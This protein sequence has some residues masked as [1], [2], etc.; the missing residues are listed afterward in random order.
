MRTSVFVLLLLAPPIARAADVWTGPPVVVT[1]GTGEIRVAPDRATVTLTSEARAKTAKDAQQQEAQSSTAVR[2]L[3][4]DMKIPNDS[5]RTTS[6]DLQQEF[7][8]TQGK[9]VPRGYVARHALEVRVD[10]L[11]QLGDLISKAVDAG[12]AAV[13]GIQF[14]VKARDELER[15]ALKKAVE[16]AR[17]R[18]DAAA[19]GASTSVASVIKIEEQRQFEPP[20]PR[21][22]ARA[23]MA[24]AAAPGPGR[25]GRIEIKSTVADGAP[26]KRRSP[27]GSVLPGA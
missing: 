26:A 4:A 15:Q 6:Y 7:D 21:M 17:A 12:S 19:S 22:F 9:Q 11:A 2:K 23:E 20:R 5:V 1:T 14:D 25:R 27:P 18:A 16:D 10:D 8:Y 24:A 3:L 13:S